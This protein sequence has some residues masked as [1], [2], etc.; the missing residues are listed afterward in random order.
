MNKELMILRNLFEYAENEDYRGYNKH[1]GLNSPFLQRLSFDN[2][3]LRLIFIQ[4][5]MRAPVNLRPLLGVRKTVNAKGMSLW[6]LAYANLFQITREEKYLA[7]AISCLDWLKDNNSRTGYSGYCWGYPYPWQDAGFFAPTGMPNC[8]VS[9]FV[10]RAFIKLYQMTRR[11]EYLTVA[12][13]T[14]DF[15]LKDLTR[16][17]EDDDMLCLSYA[18]VK[19]DWVVID[20]SALAGTL[21]AEV[22]AITGEKPLA[23]D[24]FRLLNYVVDKKTDYGAWFYSHPPE[25]SHIKHDNYHTGYIVD[26]ILDYSLA[27]QD[28]RFMDSYWQGVEYYQNNLFLADGSP[29]WMSHQI[30]PL[31]IHGAAQGIISFSKAGRAYKKREGVS[32][33]ESRKEFL[34]LAQ[35]ICSWAV[36]NLYDQNKRIFYYQKLRFYTKRFTLMRWCNAWMARALSEWLVTNQ[37]GV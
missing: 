26:A 5:V 1:D 35:K 10:G 28:E 19:M 2:K 37:E 30:Y 3:Y 13:S 9:C 8:V 27:T 4:G 17:Y 33:P 14:C 7:R 34:P 23:Q 29:K 32:G 36:T 16:I 25:R 18:P 6:A 24:A 31:D 12:R 22:A 20:T 21:L 15:L 11:E